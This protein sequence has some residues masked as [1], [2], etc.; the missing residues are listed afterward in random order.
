MICSKCG[1]SFEF[2]AYEMNPKNVT[3]A[4]FTSG[5]Y[6]TQIGK[7]VCPKCGQ[8]IYPK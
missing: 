1:F 4:L 5:N 2:P 6:A 7:P 3:T 8:E